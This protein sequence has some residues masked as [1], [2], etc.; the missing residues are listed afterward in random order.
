MTTRLLLYNRIT[1]SCF[2]LSADLKWSIEWVASGQQLENRMTIFLHWTL[3][4]IPY[5][6]SRE[7]CGRWEQSQMVF[8]F[9]LLRH[10]LIV[11]CWSLSLSSTNFDAFLAVFLI[12][13]IFMSVLSDHGSWRIRR[14]CWY[15]YTNAV[16]LVL[17]RYYMWVSRARN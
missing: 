8:Q 14:R 9:I 10:I 17:C 12:S 16:Y 5:T 13:P 1:I 11:A 6:R 4:D 7:F 15:G 2:S 3:Y